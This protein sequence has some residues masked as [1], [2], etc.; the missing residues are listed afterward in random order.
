VLD[1]R[2]VFNADDVV[3]RISTSRPR[4]RFKRL[5]GCG[6]GAEA[7]AR[8]LAERFEQREAQ[9]IARLRQVLALVGERRCQTAMLVGYFGERLPGPCGHCTRCLVPGQAPELPPEPGRPP[10]AT[11]V[12]RSALK[13]LRA[14]YPAALGEPRQ[15][16]RLLCGLSSPGLS[17]SKLS[18][19]ALFGELENY[20]FAEVLAWCSAE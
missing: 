1:D 14:A 2:A 6:L 3:T 20:P 4:L 8:T 18:R 11:Q 7:L 10:I 17:A 16:A 13:A 19:H 9:E 5:D 15:A 12:Q